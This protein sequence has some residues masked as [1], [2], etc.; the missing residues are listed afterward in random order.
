VSEC[1]E[2]LVQFLQD[3]KGGVGVWCG[4]HASQAAEVWRAQNNRACVVPCTPEVRSGLT[5]RIQEVMRVPGIA[6][7]R[8]CEPLS[9]FLPEC[10]PHRQALVLLDHFETVADDADVRQELKELALDSELSKKYK[11]I[12]VLDGAAH[13]PYVLQVNAGQKVR[14]IR[15]TDSGPAGTV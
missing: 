15:C 12:A 14:I 8:T 3:A 11:L 4:N 10:D 6:S 5:R 1:D 9:S 7:S 2:A 13:L